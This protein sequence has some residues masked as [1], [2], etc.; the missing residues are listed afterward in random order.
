MSIP[1]TELVMDYVVDHRAAELPPRAIAEVF[2]RMIW[3]LEDNGAGIQAVRAKWL[4]SSDRM[5]VAV[6]LSMEETFPWATVEELETGLQRIERNWPE[7]RS[8]CEAM[9]QAWAATM[10]R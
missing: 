10:S 3:C 5:R 6:A 7:F 8:L 2:D 4:T 1:T 9:R